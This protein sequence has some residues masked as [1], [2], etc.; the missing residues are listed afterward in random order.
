[1]GDGDGEA[2]EECDWDREVPRESSADAGACLLVLDLRRDEG[3]VAR[4]VAIG[5]G[6]D[7]RAGGVATLAEP[8]CV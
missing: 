4:D 1:M 7:E 3:V 8:S 6:C 5:V 2:G